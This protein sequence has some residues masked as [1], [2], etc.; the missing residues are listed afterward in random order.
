MTIT[1]VDPLTRIEKGEALSYLEMDSNFALAATAINTTIDLVEDTVVPDIAEVNTRVD[2]LDTRLTEAE[3]RIEELPAEVDAAGTAATLIAQHNSSSV[4]HP[5]LSAF[6]TAEADRAEAAADAAELSGGVYPDTTTGLA[7][8]AEGEYFSVPSAEDTEYLILYRDVAGVAVEIKRYPSVEYFNGIIRSDA[9]KLPAIIDSNGVEL[10][11][12]DA[13]GSASFKL[14]KKLS[15]IEQSR[16]SS[17]P[18]IFTSDYIELLGFKNDGSAVFKVSKEVANQVATLVGIAPYNP[19]TS[20]LLPKKTLSVFGDSMVQGSGGAGTSITTVLSSELSRTVNNRGIGGQDTLGVA[21][22]QGGSNLTVTVS[23]NQIPASGDVAITSKNNNI[24][25]SGGVFTGTVA[26]SVAGVDGIIST[27]SS[28]NWTFTRNTSGAITSVPAG[29]VATLVGGTTFIP[30]PELNR[31]N[32]FIVW[33]G[34]NGVVTFGRSAVVACRDNIINMI[35]HLTPLCKRVLVVSV[36]NGRRLKMSDG[37]SYEGSGTSRY[38]DVI[39]LNREFAEHYGDS[40]VDLR[41][42]M[43]NHAIYDAGLTPTATDLLDI[44]ADCIPTSL[45]ADDVHFNATGYTM[46]GKFLARQINSRGW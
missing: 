12:F 38:N 23:G 13:D 33:A 34:R 2:G 29:S 36:C 28:G 44:A 17:S 26:V 20:A 45:M 9:V 41:W 15:G 14:P 42:Y 11:G 5:E 40:Y 7:A 6:I 27:D 43:V 16:Y 19:I 24:L 32:T 8:V 21:I 30:D 22:R 37:S 35:K 18:A 39:A 1:K 10:L 25:S 46:A 31:Q 3:T 4:A